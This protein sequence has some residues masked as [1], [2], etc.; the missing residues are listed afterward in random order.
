MHEYSTKMNTRKTRIFTLNLPRIVWVAVDM[1]A[2]KD[3]LNRSQW[4]TRFIQG[5]V[6]VPK[7]WTIR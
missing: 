4:I 6:G 1:R 3:G 2:R 5:E 7:V